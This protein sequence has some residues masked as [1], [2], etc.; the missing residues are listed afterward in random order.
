MI[1]AVDI[2]HDGTCSWGE[3]KK[4][5]SQ[6]KTVDRF[7]EG[8]DKFDTNNSGLI[9]EN[10]LRALLQTLKLPC[11]EKDLHSRMRQVGRGGVLNFPEFVALCQI[12]ENEGLIP[13]ITGGH[14]VGGSQSGVGS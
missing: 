13:S 9:D 5:W 2:D 10:E 3:C 1:E 14:S 11:A 6:K 4:L 7:K 8:F 12:L